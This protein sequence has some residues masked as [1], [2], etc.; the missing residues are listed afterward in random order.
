MRHGQEIITL[1]LRMVDAA[2]SRIDRAGEGENTAANHRR[3]AGS[4]SD[5]DHQTNRAVGNFDRASCEG[6]EVAKTLN[7]RRRLCPK[8]YTKSARNRLI[9]LLLFVHETNANHF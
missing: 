3:E 2:R 1:T 7:R 6:E 9:A 8:V 5:D 4:T